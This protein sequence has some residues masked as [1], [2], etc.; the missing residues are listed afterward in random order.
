MDDEIVHHGPLDTLPS[1]F[2]DLTSADQDS[3]QYGQGDQVNPF[4]EEWLADID[5]PEYEEEHLTI[6]SPL[7]SEPSE[8]DPN[9]FVVEP[10]TQSTANVE[11]IPDHLLVIY[12]VVS[13]LHLQFLL[14]RVACNALLVILAHLLTFFDLTII[15]PFITLQSVTRTLGLDPTIQV[16]SV[17]PNCREVYPSAASKH[18]QETCIACKVGLFRS[19]QTR[20][21]N[22]HITKIPL[23]KYPYFP[24]SDQIATVLKTPGVEAL[25]DGWRVKPRRPGEYTDIFDGNICCLSLK[26]PDSNLFFSNHPHENNGPNGEL[27]IG[28]NLG[29]DWCVHSIMFPNLTD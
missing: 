22:Q 15:T 8:D 29:V 17:C 25:L 23:I 13:W 21:G 5:I 14:P 1:H 20:K 19:D 24:L 10:T 9:P 4:E 7:P 2:A 27:H 11:Q 16:L 3:L 28:V 12:A 26:A 18:I 6:T